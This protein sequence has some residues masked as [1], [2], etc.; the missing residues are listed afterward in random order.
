MLLPTVAESTSTTEIVSMFWILLAVALAPLVSRLTRGVVPEV[1]LLL[2]FGVL[3]G[4]SLFDIASAEGGVALISELGLGMLFL[5]AGYEI[6]PELLVSKTGR[7]AMVTWLLCAT[8]G[9]AFALIALPTTELTAAIA[10]AIALSSTALGTLLPIVKD[11][12]LIGT[13]LGRAVLVHGASGELLPVV[14]MA[15]LLSTRNVAASVALLLLYAVAAVLVATAQR[16]TLRRLPGLDLILRER[17]HGTGQVVLRGVMLLLIGL[18]A[19][20]A[21]F[22][23]DV[24]LGAFAAGMILRF[25]DKEFDFDNQLEGKLEALAYG[26]LVPVFFVVSGMGIALDAVSNAPEQ[27]LYVVILI[28]LVRGV[29]VW[30]VERFTDTGSGLHTRS[31]RAQLALFAATGLPIVVAVTQVAVTT[32][33]MSDANASLL[34]AGGATT[35]LIFPLITH[36]IQRGSHTSSPVR[37]QDSA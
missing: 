13:A 15:L 31:D 25:L 23:L 11:R 1:V 33:L 21:V 7:S 17:S 18:M 29:P 5:L 4:P 20:A 34:V 26:F 14:A 12:G 37:R 6:E 22:S 3:I 10:I 36:L 19:L 32:D 28:A 9:L 27:L 16:H 8:L 30:L 2:A 35:V 24:V